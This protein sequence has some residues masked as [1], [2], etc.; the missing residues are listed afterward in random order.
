MTKNNKIGY[1]VAGLGVGKAHVEAALGYDKCE[2]VAVCDI[3]PEKMQKVTDAHPEVL[4]YTDFDE[5]LKNPEIDIVSICLPSGMHAEYAV[6]AMEAGKHVLVE[7]PIDISVEAAQKIEDARIRTGKKAGGIYQNRN[8]AVMKPLKEA[9]DS[10]K[11]GKVFLGTF[12]VKWFRAQSYYE[13][14][15]AWH[16]TWAMDG[17]G[18]LINQAVHTLDI[19]QWL[20]GEPVSVQSTMSINNH[21]I[22]TEDLTASIIRFKSGATATF[23]SSTCCYPGLST[24]IQ[25]YG[26]KGAVEVNADVLKLWKIEGQD[27]RDE[28]DMMDRYG[29]GNRV[30]CAYDGSKYGHVTQVEDMVD[31]VIEDRDPQIMPKESMKAVRLIRAIYESAQTGKTVFFD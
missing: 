22:E 25:V 15:Q 10:G 4:A 18:S 9:I 3:V 29:R 20:M 21:D 26:T 13:G 19:M 16:G 14:A 1:A 7:K 24:D 5:M 28:E 2:L 23:V 11:L 30:A 6:K 27:E 31:A 8:N 12:A 17:G